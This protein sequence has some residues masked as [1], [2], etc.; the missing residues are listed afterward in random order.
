MDSER[1]N[2]VLQIYWCC[3]TGHRVTRCV[4]ERESMDVIFG[5]SKGFGLGYSQKA[6][7]EAINTWYW[8]KLNQKIEI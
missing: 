2:Q 1:E 3:W 4:D 6:D 5:S 8:R 7:R